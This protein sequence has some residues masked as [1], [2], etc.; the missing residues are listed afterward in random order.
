MLRTS[1]PVFIFIFFSVYSFT[2]YIYASLAMSRASI[3]MSNG[4]TVIKYC[5]ANDEGV[6]MTI[7]VPSH[8]HKELNEVG[9]CFSQ[10]VLLFIY[11]YINLRKMFRI[12]SLADP[13]APPADMES[14]VIC[15]CVINPTWEFKISP[16]HRQIS[17]PLP[18]KPWLRRSRGR[19]LLPFT[20][21]LDSLLLLTLMPDSRHWTLDSLGLYF[22]LIRPRTIKRC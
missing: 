10:K 16:E 6:G 8:A 20:P 15:T 2:L 17:L 19:Q 21:M 1:S 12:P 22:P 13:H 9:F 7:S 18:L 5:R 11:I 4:Q 3:S 14:H